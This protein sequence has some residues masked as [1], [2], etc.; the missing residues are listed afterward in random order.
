MLEVSKIF[1]WYRGDFEQGY[2]GIDSVEA[3]F[4]AYAAQLAQRPEDQQAIRAKKVKIALPRVRLGAERPAVSASAQRL[5]RRRE[6]F[7]L[8]R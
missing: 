7:L 4:A 5:P 3:F 2:R 6:L 8:P 1:D